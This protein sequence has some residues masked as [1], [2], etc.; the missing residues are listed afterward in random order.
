MNNKGF[1]LIEL[2]VSLAIIA[3]LS[4]IILASLSDARQKA[5]VEASGGCLKYAS[6]RMSKLKEVPETCIKEFKK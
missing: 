6:Y 3:I 2:L 5:E 4:S 1:T